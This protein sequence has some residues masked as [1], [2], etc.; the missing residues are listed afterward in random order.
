MAL[1][2]ADSVRQQC[3]IRAEL[4]FYRNDLTATAERTGILLFLSLAEKQA[5][6]LAD[7]G[8][9]QKAEPKIWADVVR[10]LTLG[11][12]ESGVEIC[13]RVLKEKFPARKANPNE[14]PNHVIVKD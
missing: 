1:A 14:L 9:D 13:G 7:R 6:V 10:E 5:V 8:L 4:E 12:L 3:W 11:R 2:S